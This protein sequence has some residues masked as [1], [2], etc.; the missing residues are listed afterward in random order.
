ML[1]D[2]VMRRQEGAELQ[3]F[4]GKAPGS[5]GEFGRATP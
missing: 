4:H 3:A 1:A 5:L 2:R